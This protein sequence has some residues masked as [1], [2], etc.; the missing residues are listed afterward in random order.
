MNRRSFVRLLGLAPTAAVLPLAGIAAAAKQVA[1]TAGPTIIDG[2]RIAATS[3][4]ADQIR[5]GSIYADRIR[6][7]DGRVRI[8]LAAHTI[9]LED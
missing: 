6:C 4:T 8:D 3:I 2:D 7:G 5:A 1:E 9:S